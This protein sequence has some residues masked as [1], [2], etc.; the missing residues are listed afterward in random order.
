MARSSFTYVTYVRT[1][2]EQLWG[3]LTSAESFRQFWFGMRFESQWTKG[4]SWKMVS[5]EGRIYD[6]GMIAEADPPHRLVL[7]W[8]HQLRPELKAEGPSV[9]AM[10]MEP[11]GSAVKLSINHFIDRE[12]SEFMAAVTIGWPMVISNIKSLLETGSIVLQEQ[13]Y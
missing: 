13:R 3:L 10:E 9:C 5:S 4:S 2:P 11:S 12:A 6:A 8:Q 1:T 7:R